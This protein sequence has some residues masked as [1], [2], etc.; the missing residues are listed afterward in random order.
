MSFG[1]RIDTIRANLEK[2][3]GV[4]PN[5][6]ATKTSFVLP[7]LIA[8]G[9][10]VFNPDEVKPEFTSDV[11]TKKGEKVDYAIVLEG[12]LIALMEAKSL[13][14]NLDDGARSQLYRYYAATPAPLAI[15]TNGI[16]YEFYTD[17]LVKNKMDNDPFFKFDLLN[18]NFAALEKLKMFSKAHID[19]GKIKD[20]AYLN[21]CILKVH[22]YLTQ[23][24][25]EP[26]REF[27]RVVTSDFYDGRYTEAAFASLGGIVQEALSSFKK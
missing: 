24:K 21:M 27:I 19:H 8:L 25:E 7:M 16:E 5:E 3:Q 1:E 14:T 4:S 12:D 10:D 22:K 11:G 20:I 17:S 18:V 9:F 26:S 13:N 23:Q 6:E 2:M 15:L